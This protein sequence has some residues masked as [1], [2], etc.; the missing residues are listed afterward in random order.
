MG[1]KLPLSTGSRRRVRNHVALLE[2]VASTP[3]TTSTTI[4]SH[5][6]GTSHHFGSYECQIS[7]LFCSDFAQI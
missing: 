4:P 2:A 6:F 3:D 7:T 1:G 5:Q